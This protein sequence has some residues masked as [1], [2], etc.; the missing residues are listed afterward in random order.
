MRAPPRTLYEWQDNI[1]ALHN[2][3]AENNHL[4]IVGVNHG[5]CIRRPY[6]QTMLL[7]CTGNFIVAS[8]CSEEC[9]KIEL[10][11]VSQTRFAKSRCL[12]NDTWQ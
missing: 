12:S 4:Q 11:Y 2:T 5:G 7:D 6:V 9:L 1:S 10:C 3:P 8:G